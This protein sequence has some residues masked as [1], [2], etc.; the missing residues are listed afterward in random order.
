MRGS[1][2]REHI[3]R[4]KPRSSC[5]ADPKGG[6]LIIVEPDHVHGVQDVRVQPGLVVAVKRRG[7]RL[8]GDTRN[9]RS[10]VDPDAKRR[11]SSLR[12]AVGEKVHEREVVAGAER[13]VS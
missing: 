5:R 12:S 3:R 1:R 10:F 13:I 9:L 6:R 8:D 2:V 7:V 11:I 4:N